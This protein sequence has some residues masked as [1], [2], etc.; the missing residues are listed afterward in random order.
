[1]KEKYGFVYIWRDRKNNRFYIGCHWGTEDDGYICSSTW[2]R[3]SYK[4][5]PQ[6]FKRRIISRTYTSKTDM[7]LKEYEWLCLIKREE[8]GK[9]YYNHMIFN[10][11][12]KN[13][14]HIASD[15]AR[16]KMS[17][18]KQCYIPWNKGKKC[19]QLSETAKGRTYSEETLTK[20]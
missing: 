6:D 4:R 10:A 12:D 20:M 17:I 11:S 13:H 15:H 8:L 5:R 16:R 3:N 7:F 9:K 2:M 1:M 19:P 14:K 18:K